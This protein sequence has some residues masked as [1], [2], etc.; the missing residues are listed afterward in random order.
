MSETQLQKLLKERKMRLADLARAVEVDKATT[1]RWSKGAIP[2]ER[3]REVAKVTGIPAHVLRP[4]LWDAPAKR[5]R[6]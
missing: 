3:V 1:T 5:R 6:A 2:P 4:D